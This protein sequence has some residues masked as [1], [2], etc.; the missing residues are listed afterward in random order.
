MILIDIIDINDE[1]KSFVCQNETSLRIQRGNEILNIYK[2][3]KQIQFEKISLMVDPQDYIELTFE[4]PHLKFN[5][6]RLNLERVKRQLEKS[7]PIVDC[8]IAYTKERIQVILV[9]SISF[10]FNFHC[11]MLRRNAR[12]K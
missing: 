9:T 2:V 5:S 6:V 12:A 8:F 10:I 11:L 1:F 4:T 7:S 3:P